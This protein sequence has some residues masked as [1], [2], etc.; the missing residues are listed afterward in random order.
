MKTKLM[1]GLTL[2]AFVLA[3]CGGQ[4]TQ[5]APEPV[6]PTQTESQPTALPTLTTAPPTETA[7][8]TA[9]ASVSGVSFANNVKPIL[10]NSCID[11]HGGKQT[12]KG[13]DVTTYE[14]LMAGSID[15][16]VVVPGNSAE[17]VLVKLVAEGKMPKRG[18]KLTP[19]QIKIISDWIA[20]GALNN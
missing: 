15:G 13:L 12:K 19:E 1:I 20:A 9:E 11:C 17:S 16:V 4:A 3:A 14:G 6:M 2:L 5:T 18:D 8:P 7:A 10:A